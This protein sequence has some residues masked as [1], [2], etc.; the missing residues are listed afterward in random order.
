M[1]WEKIQA[2]TSIVTALGVVL[3][4]V[5]LWYFRKQ[6]VTQFEDEM[7]RQYREILQTIPVKALL[8]KE[9]TPNEFEDAQ[10]GIYHYL[11]LSNEEV[12]L[13]QNK[14]VSEETWVSWRDGIKSNLSRRAFAQVWQ[15]IKLET[16]DSLSEL[17]RL[18]ES[19]FKDDPKHW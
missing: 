8:G 11:D 3:A 6:N 17:R 2:I 12:F 9:L 7:S 13:R 19:G 10:N 5:Q 1:I 18:E 16:K 15:R 14:R 4:I